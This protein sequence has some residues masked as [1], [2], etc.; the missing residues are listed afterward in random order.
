MHREACKPLDNRIAA[1]GKPNEFKSISNVYGKL[2]KF[3][4]GPDSWEHFKPVWTMYH[5]RIREFEVAELKRLKTA[6]TW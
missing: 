4:S 5:Q 3:F 6:P 2:P 1:P